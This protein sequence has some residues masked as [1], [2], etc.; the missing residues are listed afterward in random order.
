[1]YFK[2]KRIERAMYILNILENFGMKLLLLLF[3]CLCHLLLHSGHFWAMMSFA[4]I[5]RVEFLLG[6]DISLIPNPKPGGP[7]WS[8]PAWH[9]WLY[10]QLGCYL[11]N[12][13]VSWYIP[14]S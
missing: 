5:L 8:K 3:I 6:K 13:Q 7:S 10:Q 4:G 11:H 9:G 14:A 12:F 2:H 1:M